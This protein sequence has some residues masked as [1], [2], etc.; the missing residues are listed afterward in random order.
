MR[1]DHVDVRRGEDRVVQRPADHPL[2]RRTA[3]RGQP[4]GRAVL[5][6]GRAGQQCQHL[7]SVAPRVG[8]PLQ[9]HQAR[10][11]GP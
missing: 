1:L 7:V 6:Q 8:Q 9:H 5:V 11:F 4:V 3:R 10:A 2:L